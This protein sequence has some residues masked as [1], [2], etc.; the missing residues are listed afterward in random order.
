MFLPIGDNIERRTFPLVT[1][2]LIVANVMVYLIQ[3]RTAFDAMEA[4]GTGRAALVAPTESR[5]SGHSVAR[6]QFAIESDEFDGYD[7]YDSPDWLEEEDDF[8]YDEELRADLRANYAAQ[9]VTY[10]F[11]RTWG[12]IPGELMKGQVI[13]LLTHMFVHGDVFHILGN[14][15]VLWAFACALEAG[16]GHCTFLGF[17]IL[18]GLV[19]GLAHCAAD[20]SSDIPMVGAS[21]AVAGLIGAY[22]VLYGPFARLKILFFF[23]YRAFT[24]EMPAAAFGFGWFLLQTMQASIDSE[25]MGGVAWFAHIGGF[26]A[27]V[28]VAVVCRNDT[29]QEIAGEVGGRLIMQARGGQPASPAAAGVMPQTAGAPPTFCPYC[30]ESLSSGHQLAP[31]LIRCG[32][33]SCQRMVWLEAGA[34]SLVPAGTRR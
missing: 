25:G 22:T 19:G 20:M 27:G 26:L 28:V 7:D 31:N 18:F 12:L 9:K 15:I 4:A 8:M 16:F 32:N 23:F 24:F 13:G 11:F 33:E 5:A 10:E 34:S 17:Y 3:L 21:G 6:A 30:D 14:M 1:C 29:A 2:V